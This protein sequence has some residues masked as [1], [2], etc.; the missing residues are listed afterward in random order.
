MNKEEFVAYLN[1]YH[2]EHKYQP[3][4]VK[5]A[6]NSDDYW[7]YYNPG[8]DWLEDDIKLKNNKVILTY[9]KSLYDN[10]SAKKL[11]FSYEEF[12]KFMR[13]EF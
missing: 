11:E 12:L 5:T 4:W 6:S 10:N 13:Y 3:H 8:V 2:E 1:K 7:R 9:N